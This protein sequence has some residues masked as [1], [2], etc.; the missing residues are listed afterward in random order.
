M[1][2]A[3]VMSSIDAIKQ[4]QY[5]IALSK[6][7]DKLEMYHLYV[8]R[9]T[10]PPKNMDTFNELPTTNT[11]SHYTTEKTIS[12]NVTSELPLDI[13]THLTV[14]K[15][16]NT[17]ILDS[18]NNEQIAQDDNKADKSDSQAHQAIFKGPA[19]ESLGPSVPPSPTLISHTPELDKDTFAVQK[20]NSK[21][22]STKKI[23]VRSRSNSSMRSTDHLE[24]LLEPAP[25]VL[26]NNDFSLDLIL[27]KFILENLSKSTEVSVIA[28]KVRALMADRKI[29]SKISRLTKL[30]FQSIPHPEESTPQI[31]KLNQSK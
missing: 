28:E 26:H 21:N 8:R 15:T 13:T 19:P 30:L 4:I 16:S 6:I 10:L 25:S 18:K 11:S 22:Q 31:L 23:K 9:Y 5:I 29:K 12:M 17:S 2:Q 14:V 3:I 20:S 24:D 7:T 27:F 1:N